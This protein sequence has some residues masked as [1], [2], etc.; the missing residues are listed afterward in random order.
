M[1]QFHSEEFSPLTRL[2]CSS[3]NVVSSSL[4][5]SDDLYIF[6]SMEIL[7]EISLMFLNAG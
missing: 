5:I 2:L 3:Y 7:F 1:S 6:H 4:K